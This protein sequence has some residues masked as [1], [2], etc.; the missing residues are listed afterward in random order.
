M[1]SPEHP[2]VTTYLAGATYAAALTELRRIALARGLTETYK[3]RA[4]CYT[5]GASGGN[6]VLLGEQKAHAVLSFP[7]G[8]LLDDPA[9][10]LKKPGQATRAARKVPFTTADQVLALEAT[11]T[12]YIDQAI[13]LERAGAKVDFERDRELE[14]PAEMHAAFKAK[15]ALGAAFRALTPGRQRGYVLHV[16][17]AKQSRTRASRLAK[18]ERRILLGKGFHDC[19]CGRSKRMPSCDGSHRSG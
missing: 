18:C 17:G 11:L 16:T 5:L 1:P 12:R 6:V 3:W 14:L 10:I 4:P 19:I 13:E 9:G 7:K 2:A 8:A 15:P